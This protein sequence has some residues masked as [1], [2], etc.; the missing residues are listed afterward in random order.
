[1]DTATFTRHLEAGGFAPWTALG[2]LAGHVSS[3]YARP[4]RGGRVH[5]LVLV[6]DRTDPE[7]NV[8]GAPHRSSGRLGPFSAPLADVLS[9][10]RTLPT[11]FVYPL[12]RVTIVEIAATP[13]SRE[14]RQRL[15]VYT[16]PQRG[17]VLVGAVYVDVE[18]RTLYSNDGGSP[19]ATGLA[20][21][22]DPADWVK[23]SFGAAA[24][25]TLARPSVEL[26]PLFGG[27]AVS[28][29]TFFASP[30]AG[31]ALVGWNL[32]RTRRSSLGAALL[33]V[34]AL[35][36]VASVVL[37]PDTLGRVLGIV[38]TLSGVYFLG[39]TTRALFGDP[40]RKA[41]KMLAV[42]FAIGSVCALGA[43][44]ALGVMGYEM[45]A[46]QRITTA[47][48]ALVHFDRNSSAEDARKL[49]ALLQ[50]RKVLGGPN[51]AV[52]LLHE[53]SRHEIHL[54]LIDTSASASP[55]VRSAYTEIAR[56]ASQDVFRGESVRIV[57]ESGLGTELSSVSS[58]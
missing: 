33:V 48:G 17:T 56:A 5:D 44:S 47:N 24:D 38:L 30:I 36:V 2:P 46:E 39:N 20:R 49:G 34:T 6:V 11:S 54:V 8:A 57:F 18:R 1:M 21:A 3:A 27:R 22:G 35:V 26:V 9:V 19:R 40:I 16:S 58:P 55:D 50:E 25:E 10:A 23:D 12:A 42:L 53:G 41:P 51:A 32:H 52:R 37:T 15:D 31:A 13:L 7:G 28:I 43:F 45:M 4:G 29:A 14:D